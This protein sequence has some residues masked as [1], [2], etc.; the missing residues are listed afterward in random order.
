MSTCW[1]PVDMQWDSYE[2]QTLI[3]TVAEAR[4]GNLPMTTLWRRHQ[5]ST[6]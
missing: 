4:L 3:G 2:V 6:R 1:G 5:H